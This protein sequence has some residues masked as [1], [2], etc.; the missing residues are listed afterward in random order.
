MQDVPDLK[1]KLD[2]FVG[3]EA[4]E[5]GRKDHLTWVPV[6]RP[7]VLHRLTTYTHLILCIYR[8]ISPTSRVRVGIQI[9]SSHLP[10]TKKYQNIKEIDIR[11]S[12]NEY[13]TS[14][15]YELTVPGRSLSPTGP[16]IS[17]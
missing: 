8:E 12:L 17:D 1:Y 13:W 16:F 3:S 15:E 2:L 10:F 14:N 9:K 7:Y 6:Q 5:L 11:K 4:I